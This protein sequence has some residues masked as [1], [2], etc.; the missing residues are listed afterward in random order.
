MTIPAFNAQALV[1]I[2]A[3]TASQTPVYKAT[4]ALA[5]E[6][7]IETDL[8]TVLLVTAA[9]EAA[10]AL[11]SAIVLAVTHQPSST[12]DY[13]NAEVLLTGTST[14]LTASAS[15]VIRPAEPATA[16]TTTIAL[17]VEP[18]SILLVINAAVLA[19]SIMTKEWL[20]A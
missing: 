20:P 5:T 9:A 17:P 18:A 12:E 7:S 19:D 15:L 10:M 3:K 4:A 11:T 1:P 13:V 6:D 14:P 8:A 16:L 2:T